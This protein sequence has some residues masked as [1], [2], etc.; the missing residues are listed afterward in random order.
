MIEAL[1]VDPVAKP[2]GAFVAHPERWPFRDLE[3]IK[4]WAIPAATGKIYVTQAIGGD[5]A[6]I[7]V[8]EN[9]LDE[10]RRKIR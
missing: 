3:C 2:V 7:A 10:F 4:R 1:D 5:Q 9:W 8:M 6:R